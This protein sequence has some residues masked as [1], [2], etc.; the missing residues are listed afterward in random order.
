M[1]Q[2]ILIDIDEITDEQ[3]RARILARRRRQRRQ[4]M[5]RRRAILAGALVLLVLV[6][7]LLIHRYI[8]HKQE[9]EEAQRHYEEMMIAGGEEWDGDSPLIRTAAAEV[10]NTGGEKYAE[11]YGYDYWVDWCGCFISWVADQNDCLDE[12]VPKFS[13]VQEGVTWFREHD[14]WEDREY[15]PKAGDVI[16]FDYNDNGTADHVG[17][18]SAV[19]DG[20]VF[21][22]EG[23]AGWIDP[24]TGEE[25]E[26]D[27]FKGICKRNGYDL[28][29]EEI[30]GYGI[31]DNDPAEDEASE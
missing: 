16:F 18:V 5:R 8:R 28:T 11:W 2:K 30:M 7:G 24:E 29:A 17:Y 26:D 4:R 31:V 1:G 20:R 23:N 22:I 15:E 25:L 13:F 3:I 21:T 19:R 6:N 14:H 9:L 12:K 10:G 27:E